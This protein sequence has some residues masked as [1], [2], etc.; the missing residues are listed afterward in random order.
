[1]SFATDLKTL[2]VNAGLGTFGGATGT[3]Y[4]SPKAIIPTGDGPYTSIIETGGTGP[5]Q[6]QDRVN[7]YRRPTAQIVVRA[8]SYNVA[9]L[10][11]HKWYNVV[12]KIRNDLINSVFY[13][14][15]VPLQEPFDMPLDESGRAR[16]AFNVLATKRPDAV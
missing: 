7:A 16:V 11:A 1:M 9:Y 15:I 6:I 8:Q 3:I 12:A 4:I 5:L 10:L 13:H 2:G 14:K